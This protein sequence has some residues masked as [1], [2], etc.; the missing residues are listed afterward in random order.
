MCFFDLF[1]VIKVVFQ[2]SLLLFTT[3]YRFQK[4]Q[5]RTKFSP[6]LRF[7]LEKVNCVETKSKSEFR[8]QY[9]NFFRLEMPL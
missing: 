9:C 4:A 3:M 2:F 8:G 1:I 7:E 5:I 6:F